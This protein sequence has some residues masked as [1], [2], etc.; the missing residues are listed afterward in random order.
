MLDDTTRRQ[1]RFS[2]FL[3]SFAALMMGGAL[4]VRVVGV[5]LGR[6]AIVLVAAIAVIVAARVCTV[7][8]LRAD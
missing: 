7:R 5:R 6:V 8:R 4:I 3:Q 1:L 2:L